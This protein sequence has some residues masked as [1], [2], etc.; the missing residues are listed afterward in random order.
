MSET[1]AVQKLCV[2]QPE[3]AKSAENSSPKASKILRLV[4][5]A[6]TLKSAKLTPRRPKNSDVRT[7]EYLTTSEVE[8]LVKAAKETGRQGLRDGLLILLA[9]RHG[10]RVSE[11]T[12]LKWEQVSFD[13]ACLHVTRAKNGTAAT[14]PIEGDELRLLRQLQRMTKAS[15]YVF[16]S[17]RQTPLSS[18]AVQTLVARAG[19]IAGLPFP[20]HPH[21][22]RH[23]TGFAL[24]NK[25]ADT[26]SIQGYL[27]HRNIQN[28]VVYTALAP[29]RFK[30]FGAMLK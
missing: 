30:S 23:S 27:G 4:G 9:Y 17:E 21:M 26:R 19:V 1:I 18:R 5:T 6:Q 20:V 2:I 8:K 16:L 12:A 22:L 13:T 10:L 15:P 29:S 7:R 24:A 28:T 3:S 14:H 25:G 11:L